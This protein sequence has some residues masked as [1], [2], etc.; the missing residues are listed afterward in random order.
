[1]RF[2]LRAVS[3]VLWLCAEFVAAQT[4]FTKPELV[5]RVG[6]SAPQI[7]Q[8]CF[9]P[10]GK[11]L[12]SSA[13]GSSIVLWDVAT[14][15]DIST[16]GKQ[17]VSAIACSPDGKY[18]ATGGSQAMISLSGEIRLWDIAARKEAQKIA[19]GT[20]ILRNGM[21]VA[22]IGPVDA[23]AFSPDGKVLAA[24]SNGLLGDLK[25]FDVESGKELLGW[26]G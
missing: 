15:N 3:P 21:R 4:P 10:D 22:T 18:V 8:A 16:L 26:K 2:F 11:L 24:G 7:E 6:G 17:A 19:E 12:A 23:L 20:R 13:D 9:V 1:M 14:G 25:L 5:F